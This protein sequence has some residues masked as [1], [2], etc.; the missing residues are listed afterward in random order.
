[1]YIIYLLNYSHKI[2]FFIGYTCEIC[3]KV[4]VSKKPFDIHVGKHTEVP[5]DGVPVDESS[6]KRVRFNEI[7]GFTN[8]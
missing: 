1:M 2:F 8:Y 5:V 7:V 6:K 4:Y 3:S